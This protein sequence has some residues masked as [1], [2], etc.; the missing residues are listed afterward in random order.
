[1]T[2]LPQHLSADE[3]RAFGQG[4][5]SPEAADACEQHLAEC[6]ACCRALAEAPADSFE[7]QLRAA[8]QEAP[9][10]TTADGG[11][12]TLAEAPAVPPAL[13]DHARYRVLGLVGQ[14]GMGA[15][16]RA[17]HRHM[18][19]LV[20]LKVINPGLIR[21]PASV[22][23]FQQEVRAAARLHHPNIVTAHDAD[24][25]DGLHFLVME[26]VEGRSLAD[27]VSERGPL[28]VAEACECARQAALGLQ[29]AHEQGM[30]H[31][32]VKPHNLMLTPDGTV[33]IL[34]FGLAR[35][36]RTPDGPLPAGADAVAGLTGAGT[37]MGTA[38]YV[39]PEQAADPRTADIRADVYSLGC[40]LFHLLAGRPP[41]E[42]GIVPEK[43]ARHTAGPLP[44][45]PGVPSGLAAVVARMTAKDPA[46]RY[47]TPA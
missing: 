21:N 30:V 17:E 26:H 41:F 43:I 4:H 25:A 22:Q 28:P 16:Y 20:A 2:M 44:P 10:A 12:A 19:R 24:E 33:K 15:V 40:T 42:G 29:H 18:D 35:L 37:I 27:L 1:M 46:D 9:L 6:D 36:A 8:R 3:L 5:L 11:A 23:R 38:D 7:S 45:L 31:R 47:A 13:V 32:D 34:D 39:A 14:G